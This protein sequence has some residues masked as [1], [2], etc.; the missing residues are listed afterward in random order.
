MSTIG[1]IGA[2][3]MAE[4]I[5][6]GII[7]AGLFQPGDV[8]VSD[9]RPERLAQLASQYQVLTFSEN[10]Q[11]AAHS[12]VLVLSVKPYVLHDALKSI[13]DHVKDDAVIV[14]VI[15]GKRMNDITDSLGD[16]P[17]VRVMPNTPALINEGASALYANA[18]AQS[19]VQAIQKLFACVGQA[20]IVDSEALID[21]VTAVSGSGPAY[22]YLLM[23]KMIDAGVALGLTPDMAR[24]LVLQTAKGACL[25]ATQADSQGETPADLTRK[26]ATPG[27]TT[28]AALNGFNEGG[29][30]ELV[31]TALQRAY[32][33][34]QTLSEGQ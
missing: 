16:V 18:R 11:V 23:E 33:R 24:T 10:A 12:D 26:V 25:L 4:A 3:N 5:L 1:F 6:Q 31:Q 2:G 7:S 20:V 13:Q 28:E 22:Y 21:A 30:G 29:F 19:Q 34:S 8:A 15:A 9:I 32:T 17:V 27:G 14:S